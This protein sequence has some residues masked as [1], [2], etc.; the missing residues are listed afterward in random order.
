MRGFWQ[1]SG[2]A[3]MAVLT[4]KD[5]AQQVISFFIGSILKAIYSVRRSR[6]DNLDLLDSN[7]AYPACR[8]AVRTEATIN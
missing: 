7:Q 2:S 3:A 6:R 8:S 5:M 1:L 4:S